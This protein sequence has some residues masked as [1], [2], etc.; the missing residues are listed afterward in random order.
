TIAASDRAKPATVIA[1][2]NFVNYQGAAKLIK[3]D[4]YGHLLSGATFKVLGAKGH[5]IQTGLTRYNQGDI[6]A[7]HFGPGQYRF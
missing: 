6:I 5:T 2:A 7:E 3:K 1:T 4:V